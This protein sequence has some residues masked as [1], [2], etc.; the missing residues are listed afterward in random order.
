[1]NPST[2]PPAV[3]NLVSSRRSFVRL[4]ALSLA[5]LAMPA[6]IR[7]QAAGANGDLRVAVIGLN[8]RGAGHMRTIIGAKGARLAALC[9]VD[10]RVLA[11]ARADAV[12]RGAPEPAG[13]ADYRKV[14]ESPEIDAVMIATPN[15]THTLIAMTAIASGKHVYVEKPVSHNL[16]EG[17]LL[18]EAAA[19]R[20]NLIV[21]HGM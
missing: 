5:G 4:G 20:P 13:F 17:R 19:K 16:R 14:C 3:S 7:A 15:H 21:M 2:R 12:A 9:D 8:G 6:R 18:V 10:E 11:R 1:M